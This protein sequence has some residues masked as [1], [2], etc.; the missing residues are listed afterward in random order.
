MTSDDEFISESKDVVLSCPHKDCVLEGGQ[1]K[2]DEKRDEIF[3]NETLAPDEIDRLLSPKVFTNF[4]KYDSKGEHKITDISLEDNLIIKGNN[5]LALHSLLPVYSGKI[6]LI[7][8][9]PPY[10]T[11]NDSF[12]Y[13]DS[14]NHSSWLTFIKNRVEIARVLLRDDGII[15]INIGDEEVHYLKVLCDQIFFRENFL[16]TVAR[17]A[18][19]A[20]NLGTHFAPS[21]DF[22][23]CYA[24][25][26]SNLK[27]F[28]DDVDESLYKKIEIEG[29]KKGEKYRDDVAF[30]QTSQKDLRPNQKYFVKCPDGTLVL[31]PC[32]V[33]DEVLREG[34][35]RW[36]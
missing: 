17:V 35:G 21:I 3:W 12:Q 18:K 1:T 9:D 6:K 22:L 31:P 24:K 2:E 16:N 14:F 30:Y 5:L 32:S 11:G 27:E 25:N 15:F 33:Q 7:Y 28:N 26:I 23:L 34:D 20:S 13:N 4:K 8:I 29:T 10:N 19:T 36:R